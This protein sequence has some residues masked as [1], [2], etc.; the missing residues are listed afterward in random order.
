[1]TKA[2]DVADLLG[3]DTTTK[4]A[5]KVAAK[6]AAPVK[7]E[8]KPA[9]K[10]VAAKAE[11][12]APTKKI[13][14]DKAPA[15]KKQKEPVV[16]AEGERDELYARIKKLVKKPINSKDLAVKLEIDTRKLRPVLYSLQSQG[17]VALELGSSKVAGL[18]VS[19]A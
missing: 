3:E 6:K 19:P 13:K 2:N 5:K 8:A 17:V 10:K 9:A 15:A 11:A 18:T 7:A 16:F 4:P 14:A 12:P 1:M